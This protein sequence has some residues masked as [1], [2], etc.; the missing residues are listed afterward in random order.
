VLLPLILT[1]EGLQTLVA[2][3]DGIAGGKYAVQQKI[4]IRSGISS[5]KKFPFAWSIAHLEECLQTDNVST[6]HKETV[7]ALMW[8][9][10]FYH[11]VETWQHH[12]R[13]KIVARDLG[14]PESFLHTS[15]QLIAAAYLYR[16]GNRIGLSLENVKGE[17]NP[18]LYVRGVARDRIFIEVKAP[19][20][21]QWG[22]G[23]GNI[24]VDRIEASVESCI[25]KSRDQINRTHRGVL[26]ISSSYAA[27]KFPEL[28]EQCIEKGLN[29]LGRSRKYLAAVV[30]ISPIGVSIT[31][32]GEV[33]SGFRFSLTLNEHYDGTNPIITRAG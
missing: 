10:T 31:S 1:P 11:I 4:V 23:D 30:G 3:Y 14:K 22:G 16:A 28:L 17:P 29:S 5:I 6:H 13:F 25:K 21:L 27:N 24:Y 19:E 2:K 7:S 9:S 12:P 20:A 15:S 26:V 32:R 33:N 8:L 18:D